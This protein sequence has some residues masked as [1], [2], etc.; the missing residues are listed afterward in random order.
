MRWWVIATFESVSDR[1]D[2]ALV[3]DGSGGDGV[4]ILRQSVRCVV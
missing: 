3:V 2:R 1:E 4:D